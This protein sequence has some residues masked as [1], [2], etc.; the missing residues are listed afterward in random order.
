MKVK[1]ENWW[2]KVL[3]SLQTKFDS[4]G[5]IATNGTAEKMILNEILCTNR[6]CRTNLF[7]QVS[8]PRESRTC[9]Y[10][11]FTTEISYST[12]SSC[13]CNFLARIV[14]QRTVNEK[15]RFCNESS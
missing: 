2:G 3:F 6:E 15:L 5:W 1:S 4:T 7:I 9:F 12:S 13:L 14:H 10:I 8:V 11:F